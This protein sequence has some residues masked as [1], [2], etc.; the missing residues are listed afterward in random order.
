M[1]VAEVIVFHGVLHHAVGVLSV[2]L[3]AGLP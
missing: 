2:P 3:S 1:A